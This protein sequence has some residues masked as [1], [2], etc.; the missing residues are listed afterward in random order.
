MARPPARL[1]ALTSLRF[2]AAAFIVLSH[3]T[4]FGIPD[5]TW[6]PFEL[7]LGVS[8]FFVL[9][10]FILTHVYPRLNGA[11]D[12]GRFL[13]ARFARIWPTHALTLLLTVVLFGPPTEW[14]PGFGPWTSGLLNLG[15]LQSFVPIGQ[16]YCSWNGVSWSISTEFG[17]YLGFLFLIRRFERSWPRKLLGAL[18]LGCVLVVVC[19]AARLAPNTAPGW[20]EI[21]TCGL[22]YISPAARLFEFTLG[23]C[24][25]I[26]WRKLGPRLRP[27]LMAG[28]LLEAAALGLVLLNLYHVAGLRAAASRVGWVGPYGGYWLGVGPVCSLS[29]LLL[30]LVMAGGW[31]LLS[32]ALSVRPMVLLGEI[33]FTV[34]LLHPVL[35]KWFDLHWAE[36]DEVPGWLIYAW[37][38]ALLVSASHLLW[39]GVER[40]LRDFLVGLWPSPGRCQGPAADTPMSRRRRWLLA[41]EVVAVAALL[42]APVWL[43]K[44]RPVQR[45][46]SSVAGALAERGRPEVRD[47]PVAGRCVLR[48]AVWED[49]LHGLRLKLAWQ[50]LQ[51]QP[52]D[53]HLDLEMLD[54]AGRTVRTLDVPMD[55]KQRAVAAGACWLEKVLLPPHL[56]GGA[57][58]LALGVR[59]PQGPLLP[60]GLGP[61]A[62]A[63]RRVRIPLPR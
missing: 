51:A 61:D 30:I 12:R 35:M 31:G 1:N 27:G 32:R 57:E 14:A 63:D 13:L 40:P 22:L 36:F 29:F 45:V 50:S 17:F 59:T 33:S 44:F 47:V 42:A 23:M 58:Q 34:Y 39:A 15:M 43:V 48:G 4:C 26:L 16:V 49:A 56:L 7:R 6:K 52:L 38:W 41:G 60:I 9:S 20:K 11:A 54:A 25:A 19:R 37:F 3:S 53:L 46:N 62:P 24:G 18:A 21:D 10:G 8:F 5:Q 2:L 28:T 55:P